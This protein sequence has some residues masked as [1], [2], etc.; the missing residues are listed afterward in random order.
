M[1]AFETGAGRF[2][3][4]NG[5]VKAARELD[6]RIVYSSVNNAVRCDD[7]RTPLSKPAWHSFESAERSSGTNPGSTAGS[8]GGGGAGGSSSSAGQRTGGGGGADR[9]R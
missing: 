8:D 2:R 5:D 9:I 1:T 6:G 7:C 3:D 4:W